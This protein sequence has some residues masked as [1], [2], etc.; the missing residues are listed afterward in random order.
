MKILNQLQIRE[1]D[2][3]TV[4]MEPIASIDLMERAAKACF[5]WICQNYNT[6]KKLILLCGTG[7]NGGDGLALYRMLRQKKYTCT[8]FEFEFGKISSHNYNLNKSK[9]AQEN[10]KELTHESLSQIQKNEVIIDA[11]L[12]TGLNRPVEGSLK[13]IIQVL[14]GMPNTILSID[15]PTGLFSDFNHENHHNGIVQATH[16]LSFQMP[17]LAF[18]LPEFGEKSGHFDLLDI[19]ILP[20]YLEKVST[21]Y[22]Y[23][24]AEKAKIYFKTPKKFDHKGSNG[25]LL[26]IAGSRGKMGA[27]ILAAR[28]ALRTGAGKLSVLTPKC[29]IDILQNTIPEAIIETNHGVN[30]ISGYYG[31]NYN[32]ISIGPGMGTNSDAKKFLESVLTSSSAQMVID[33][34]AINIIAEHPKLKE[35]LPKNSIITPHPKEFERLVGS[36]KTEQEKLK[37]L[38]QFSANHNLI[39]ILK[40]AHSAI[41]L[42]DGNIWFNS[43]GNPAMATAGSGDVLTGIIGGLLAKGYT[44]MEASLMGV[45]AH[46]YS[47]DILCE[48]ISPAFML[49]S[50]LINGLNSVWRKFENKSKE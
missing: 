44:P 5:E 4:L 28:A 33:A 26:L 30:S 7:N 12:G 34:D 1:A 32:T 41:A 21:P 22:H 35:I 16:T 36:W 6:D 42:P 17:K 25:N 46:G 40:G 20:S 10:F 2:R 11:I 43:S 9:I 15:I 18:L 38:I 23:L 27:A 24:T 48:S 29:G 49:A 31:L 39:C 45:F 37:L 8:L 47:A 14:N 13:R 3:Q 50:D 19:G